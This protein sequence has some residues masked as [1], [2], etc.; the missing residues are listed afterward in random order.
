MSTN[1]YCPFCGSENPAVNQFCSNCGADLG[2]SQM[3]P[4]ETP[5]YATPPPQQPM[6]G[7]PAYGATTVYTT[8]QPAQKSSSKATTGLV[9]GIISLAVLSWL[10]WWVAIWYVAIMLVIPIVG[11]VVS[12]KGM[13]ENKTTG[14]I[15]LVLNIIAIIPIAIA[16]VI[17]IIWIVAIA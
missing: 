6:Y 2:A 9:L 1:K 5:V 10:S 4:G 15:G 8:P 14:V 17:L 13:S 12:S 16:L 3:K 11:I 7:Q